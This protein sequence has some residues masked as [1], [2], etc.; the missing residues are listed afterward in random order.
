MD[1]MKRKKI[2]RRITISSMLLAACVMGYFLYT[3]I[4][5]REIG[6]EYYV[7]IVTFLSLF[8]ILTDVLSVVLTKGFEGKTEAQIKAYKI[9]ALLDLVGLAGLA[10]FVMA[11]QNNGMMGAI[12]YAAAIMGKRKF[13]EEYR[14]ITSDEDGDA[15][16]S[17]AEAVETEAEVET[18][19]VEKT[20]T[21]DTEIEKRQK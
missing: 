1:E 2:E 20:E 13:Y 3:M 10:Y 4:V 9:F 7:V 8:W 17:E 5:R 19:E 11:L 18:T 21:E 14:G 12:I 15:A 6:P 16:E